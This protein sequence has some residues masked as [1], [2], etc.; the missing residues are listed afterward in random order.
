MTRKRGQKLF[1]LLYVCYKYMKLFFDVK[2]PNHKI[3]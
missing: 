3:H 2:I 1:I